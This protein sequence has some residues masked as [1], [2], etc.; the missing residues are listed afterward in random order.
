MNISAVEST[1]L[2]TVGYDDAL[3]ILQ[4]EFRNGAIYQYFG[5]ATATYEALLNALSKGSYFNQFIRG[6]FPYRS[7]L[8][9]EAGRCSEALASEGAR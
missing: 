4:L 7:I 5:V 3:G 6:H 1:T 2:A 9:P 8:N